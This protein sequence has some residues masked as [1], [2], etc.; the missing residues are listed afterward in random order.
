MSRGC[1]PG[2]RARIVNDRSNNGKIV[3][4]VR[5]YFYPEEVEGAAWPQ[6]VL[7]PWV[8]TSLS[9][10]LRSFY[11]EDNKEAP[12]SMTIVV[13]DEDLQPLDDDDDGLPERVETERPRDAV[14]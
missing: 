8:V 2:I 4:V 11:I 7:H 5:A 1:K 14:T 6:E 13:D 10:P 12:P 9:G 3:L